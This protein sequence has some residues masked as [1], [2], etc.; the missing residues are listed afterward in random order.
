M[1][2]KILETWDNI[3]NRSPDGGPTRKYSNALKEVQVRAS[4][5][6]LKLASPVFAAMLGNGT[7]QEGHTL[8]EE[9]CVEIGFPDDDP[10][11]FIILLNI[12]HCRSRLVPREVTFECLVEI[13][14]LVDKYDMLGM[15]KFYS[16]TWIANLV[17]KEHNAKP[18]SWLFLFWVFEMEDNFKDMSR[19]VLEGCDENLEAGLDP[20]LSI[21]SSV[22]GK[23]QTV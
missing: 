16:D 12:C 3:G 21:P 8:D 5:K 4:S 22:I 15:V 1:T 20:R 2:D 23:S 7:F 9:G 10:E 19:T 14:I 18:L 17:M 6:H 13:A 11:A